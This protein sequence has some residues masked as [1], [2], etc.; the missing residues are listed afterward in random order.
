[1]KSLFKFLAAAIAILAL[2]ALCVYF[3]TSPDIAKT[4]KEANRFHAV[5]V[6]GSH[7][8]DALREAPDF[9]AIYFGGCAHIEKAG[10]SGEV[11]PF[12]FVP[13]VGERVKFRTVADAL[14]ANSTM[15]RDFEPCRHA[16]V[17]YMK[18]FPYRGNVAVEL[19]AKGNV[20]KA[21]EPAFSN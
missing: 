11:N 1:M 12:V 19:D 8:L 17:V 18:I 7:L 5:A 16:T 3:V 13:K 10:T 6:Q 2:T 21:G 20:K 15:L 9:Q 14:Q 4:Q